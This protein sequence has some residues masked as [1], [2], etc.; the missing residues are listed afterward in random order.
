MCT[1]PAQ[2]QVHR[3]GACNCTQEGSAS[4]QAI[5]ILIY[6]NACDKLMNA[7]GEHAENGH[8]VCAHRC[9]QDT[10]ISSC[11][12]GMTLQRMDALGVR[13]DQM[14]QMNLMDLLKC[15]TCASGHD[16]CTHSTLSVVCQQG[17]HLLQ[18][19][20]HAD[21]RCMAVCATKTA[22]TSSSAAAPAAPA[23]S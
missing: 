9:L 3:S 8:V 20:R 14:N 21:M 11:K 7:G 10:C 6:H 5:V 12:Q 2:Q 15:T 16:S 22:T 1:S 23:S 13:M 4:S 18:P 17:A 19:H